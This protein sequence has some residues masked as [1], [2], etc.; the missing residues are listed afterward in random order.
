MCVVRPGLRVPDGVTF[1]V[2]GEELV[3]QRHE[4]LAHPRS[5]SDGEAATEMVSV[6]HNMFRVRGRLHAIL[7]AEEHMEGCHRPR[8]RFVEGVKGDTGSA[9]GEEVEVGTGALAVDAVAGLAENA[10]LCGRER[11]LAGDGNDGCVEREGLRF[12]I[13]ED[14]CVHFHRVMRDTSV[15]AWHHRAPLRARGRMLI[16]CRGLVENR[17]HSP[18]D[19]RAIHRRRG[20]ASDG[21]GRGTTTA[22]ASHWR[23]VRPRGLE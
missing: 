16:Q 13:Q 11:A 23:P 14:V 7:L 9:H 5:K 1:N 12:V 6:E 8:A 22:V 15:V 20:C 18:A 10:W 4:M 17:S 21:G 2:G 3:A 19:K